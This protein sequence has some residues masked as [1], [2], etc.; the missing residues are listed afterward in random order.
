M[1]TKTKRGPQI[2]GR[3]LKTEIFLRA[4]AAKIRARAEAHNIEHPKPEDE[5]AGAK[6]RDLSAEVDLIA[7][8]L[9]E[10]KL[11]LSS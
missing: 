5:S 1:K 8:E 3:I 7:N 11:P 9:R 4:I 6:L 2:D 10:P